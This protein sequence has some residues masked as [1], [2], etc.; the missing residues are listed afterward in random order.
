MDIILANLEVKLHIE[1]YFISNYECLLKQYLLIIILTAPISSFC[2]CCCL[3]CTTDF[4]S[5]FYNT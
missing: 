5:K 4:Y 3:E 1:M 2:I